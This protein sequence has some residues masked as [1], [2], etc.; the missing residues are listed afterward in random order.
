MTDEEV[1]KITDFLRAQ[2]P[3]QYNDEIT[4]QDV[5]MG[6]AGGIVGNLDMGGADD[7]TLRQAVQVILES[8]RASTS[9]LQTR[10]RIG[11]SRAARI[12]DE[13]ESRGIIGPSNGAKPREILISSLDEL[14]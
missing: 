13:L 9:H 8:K 4:M 12:I 3:P 6:G 2:M 5:Q 14:Q 1:M 10:L 11:Y 7:A